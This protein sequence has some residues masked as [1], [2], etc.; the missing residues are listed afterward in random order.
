MSWWKRRRA[1]WALRA[2]DA[3]WCGE[4]LPRG[5]WL[6]AADLPLALAQSA[7]VRARYDHL[8]VL[9]AATSP[10]GMSADDVALLG[11]EP[12][13]SAHPCA[14]FEA[15]V[16][17][18]IAPRRTAV[19]RRAQMGI[20][21]AAVAASVV[22]AFFLPL[23]S[24]PGAPES[25]PPAAAKADDFAPR[26]DAIGSPRLVLS[27]ACVVPGP[28]GAPI[29]RAERPLSCP[30]SGS[31]Q[32]IVA[33]PLARGLSVAVFALQPT[34]TGQWSAVPHAPTPASVGAVRLDA[35]AAPQSVGRPHRVGVNH[36]E[37]AG[38]LVVV[39]RSRDIG[40]DELER[41]MELWTR[42]LVAPPAGPHAPLEV[43]AA[44]AQGWEAVA[45]EPFEVLAP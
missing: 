13:E 25:A 28:D 19:S 14:T 41:T 1:R 44:L 8:A 42:G 6:S 40:W 11:L 15:R 30:A 29:V 37:G 7:S 22:L 36:S 18:A 31:L 21:A 33:D 27:G 32:P 43:P 4:E 3:L 23:G 26:G 45:V 2:F 12:A 34:K 24:N 10:G 17:A 39:A 9:D 35:T 20:A 38:Y 5:L 16:L